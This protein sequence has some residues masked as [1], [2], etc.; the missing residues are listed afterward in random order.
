MLLSEPS[1]QLTDEEFRLIRDL[2]Y[3][4][5]GLYFDTDSKYLL[6]RRLLQRVSLHGLSGFREYYQFLKYD[7]R[8]DEEIS[9]IMDILTTNETYFFREAFQL[10][11]F[12]D[13]ILPELKQVKER[14]KTLR[15]WSAG[16]STGEEPYTIAMLMLEMNCFHGWR[17][18]IVGSDISQRV[19]QHAR[20]GVYT[21]SSFRCT[22]E[23]Y[24][25]RY[26]TPVEGGY[27]INDEVR[28]LVTIT[29]MNLFDANRLALLGKMDVIFCR[30]VIIYFDEASKKRVIEAFHNTLRSGGY[31]LLG[32]S[33]SLM[34]I[35]T[36]FA[37]RHLK[38]D[39]VYQKSAATLGGALR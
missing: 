6:D 12:T 28:E 13:E 25:H 7:R 2:I 20:K 33:E 21:K 3:N 26:F 34:N 30:N 15:I 23:R 31:L 4:H 32:H 9:D 38:N 39:M 35:S 5:C 22:E 10:K 16:C 11:A 8:K 29:H 19:V 37:L 18:E 17:I 1:Q 14:E 27:R 24:L 36:A